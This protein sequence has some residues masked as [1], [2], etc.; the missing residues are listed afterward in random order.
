MQLTVIEWMLIK[1]F[2]IINLLIL[3]ILPEKKACKCVDS[4]HM[5]CLH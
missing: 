4:K 3:Q 1:T 5:A 2:L